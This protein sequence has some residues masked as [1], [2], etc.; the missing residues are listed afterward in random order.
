MTF[1]KIGLANCPA[2]DPRFRNVRRNYRVLGHAR[3]IV[4][5]KEHDLL[6]SIR[7]KQSRP[8]SNLPEQSP[9]KQ[10][11]PKQ[12]PPERDLPERDLPERDLRARNRPRS[13]LPEH[14]RLE[15][16]HLERD[17]LEHVHLEHDRR[18]GDTIPAFAR[19]ER[20]HPVGDPRGHVHPVGDHPIIDRRYRDTFPCTVPVSGAAI[21]IG[22]GIGRIIGVIGGLG[23]APA[24]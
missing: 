13:N 20:D 19:R 1:C 5:V 3:V 6:E 18:G 16:V 14:V 24:P 4:P 17:H 22:V 9:P 8:R 7:P 10:S 11:P 23:P 2:R 21:R 15:H 12:S